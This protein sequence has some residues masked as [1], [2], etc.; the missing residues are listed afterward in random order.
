MNTLIQKAKYSFKTL[1]WILSA[2]VGKPNWVE[3]PEKLT[4]LIT[5]FNPVRMKKINHQIRNILKCEFVDKLIISNHNPDIH[6]ED[7]IKIN[8][9]RLTILNQ[10]VKRG[11]GFRWLVANGF[12]F[13]YLIVIDDDFLISSQQLASLFRRL[14]EEPNIPHGLAGMN[15]LPAGGFEYRDKENVAVDFLCEVYAV[16]KSHLDRFMEINSSISFDANIARIVDSTADFMIISQTGTSRPK[17]H[18]VGRL[19]RDETFK[20]EGVAV[21]KNQTFEEHVGQI[22][23]ALKSLGLGER[24]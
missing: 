4:V 13:K 21:H 11:C 10:L 6:I 3:S 12:D 15:C 9:E 23:D 22:L 24:C 17:I 5:Y 7:K 19:F 8:E 18:D 14:L 16:T 2:Y 20:T 1:L